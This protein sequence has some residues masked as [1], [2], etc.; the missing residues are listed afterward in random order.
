MGGKN[1][2]CLQKGH[3]F[4][5]AADHSCTFKILKHAALRQVEEW[6]VYEN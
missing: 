4:I 5:H 2:F 1:S 6:E 3:Y